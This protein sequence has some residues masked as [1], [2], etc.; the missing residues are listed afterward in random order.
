MVGKTF[1]SKINGNLFKVVSLFTDGGGEHYKVL[2]L[3]TGRQV[4]CG[5]SWFEKGIMQNLKEVA[6]NEKD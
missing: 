1:K 3:A 4:V 2:D 5:R 6:Q